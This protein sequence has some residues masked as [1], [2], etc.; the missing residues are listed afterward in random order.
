MERIHL[1]VVIKS[2]G[3]GGAERLVV[4]SLPYLDRERF[5]YHFSYITPWKSTLVPSIADAGFAVTCLG[6][7]VAAQS[8]INGT[9][10]GSAYAPAR[11]LRALGLLPSA[12]AQLMQLMQRTQCH[13]LQA[14]LPASGI[15]AR[16]A[17]RR[18]HVPVAYTE[19]NLQERYH[20][21]TRAMNRVTY[22]WN[23]IVPRRL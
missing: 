20:P 21:V 23:D 3:L 9:N 22:G 12:L 14:D 2:L 8:E 7:G 17:G 15:I 16:V 6:R 11:S 13:L 19:H 1:T 18:M 4:D 10:G 5:N